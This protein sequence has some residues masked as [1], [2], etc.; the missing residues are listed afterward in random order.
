MMT[1]ITKY[2]DQELSSEEAHKI[3]R[4]LGWFSMGLAS[5][6][7]IAPRGLSRWLDSGNNPLWR[8]YGAREFSAGLGILHGRKQSK[9]VWARVAGDLVDIATLAGGLVTSRRKDR[10]AGAL[11]LVVAVTILDTLCARALRP[12]EA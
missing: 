6:E 5:L 11:G 12:D 7:I 3:A 9:W 1:A 4:F 10:V 8:F 2:L